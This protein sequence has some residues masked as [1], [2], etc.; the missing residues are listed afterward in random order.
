MD[1]VR[2]FVGVRLPV[3]VCA[4]PSVGTYVLLDAVHRQSRAVHQR[5]QQL[6]LPPTWTVDP[7]LSVLTLHGVSFAV[8]AQVTDGA[9]LDV[10]ARIA[11]ECAAHRAALCALTTICI[12]EFAPQ[13]QH[14]QQEHVTQPSIITTTTTTTTTPVATTLLCDPG[15]LLNIFQHVDGLTLFAASRVCRAWHTVANSRALQ[16]LRGSP[17]PEIRAYSAGAASGIDF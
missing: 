12:E 5:R 14:Q 15:I 1:D 16:R 2:L 10:L 9:S 7:H 6:G 4:E 8:V 3:C 17:S 11:D 13:N